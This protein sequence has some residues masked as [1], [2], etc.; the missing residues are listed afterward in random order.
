MGG[1]MEEGKG[2]AQDVQIKAVDMDDA[3]RDQA[4]SVA[5]EA[6]VQKKVEKEVAQYIKQKFDELHG[7]N[8]HCVVG[9]SFGS[10]CTHETGNFIYFYM[11]HMAVLL[12]KSG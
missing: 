2:V 11:N 7:A 5:R 1:G 6:F 10:F 8:W 4:V 3:L 12:F 9:K